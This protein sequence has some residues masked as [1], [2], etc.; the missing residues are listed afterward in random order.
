LSGLGTDIGFCEKG[1]ETFVYIKYVEFFDKLKDYQAVNK[2]PIHYRAS[3]L[4]PPR[5]WLNK[6]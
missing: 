4:I 2:Y 1:D 6:L 3:Y 5:N